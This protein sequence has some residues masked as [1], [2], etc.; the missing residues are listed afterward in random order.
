MK[1]VTREF[2]HFDRVVTPW[3]IR[4]FIDPDAEFVFVP[5]GREDER[6]TD[7]NP[8]SLPGTAL[9]E[10]DEKGTTFE[11]TLA[12]Y[13][14]R[15]PALDQLAAVVRQGVS[16]ILWNTPTLDD[17]AGKVA[18]GVFLAVEGIVLTSASDIKAIERAYVLFDGIYA[19][20]TAEHALACRSDAAAPPG[21]G[22]ARWRTSFVASLMVH[23]RG[24]GGVFDG[25]KPIPEG[26]VFESI[27]KR[28]RES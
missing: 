10:H 23:A 2:V 27:L 18:E 11:K 7:A 21:V 24:A 4:R 6:P 17:R 8:F 25:L 5:W 14:L 3:L 28:A 12:L 22:S 1:W 9:T 19:M 13:E 15:D 20:F 16:Q 26:A